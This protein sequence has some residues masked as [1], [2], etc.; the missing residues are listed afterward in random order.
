MHLASSHMGS[1]QSWVVRLGARSLGADELEPHLFFLSVPCKHIPVGLCHWCPILFLVLST[2]TE[3]MNLW[4]EMWS[5]PSPDA[6]LPCG[7][8]WLPSLIW[9]V[10]PRIFKNMRLTHILYDFCQLYYLWLC[11]ASLAWCSSCPH[12]IWMVY[13]GP[14]EW[15]KMMRWWWLTFCFF[16][17]FFLPST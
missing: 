2:S 16:V 7:F 15:Y 3:E 13:S 8:Q 14:L 17:F 11:E 10:V 4:W 1:S 5:G 12:L 6:N 9:L